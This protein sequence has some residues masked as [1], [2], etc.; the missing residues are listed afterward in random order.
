MVCEERL[1]DLA[2][3]DMSDQELS[4]V[5]LSSMRYLHSTLFGSHICWRYHMLFRWI[6]VTATCVHKLSANDL[7]LDFLYLPDENWKWVGSIS[8]QRRSCRL[9]CSSM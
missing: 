6:T 2:S 3:L 7:I 1:D 9:G 5:Y 8:R 4:P